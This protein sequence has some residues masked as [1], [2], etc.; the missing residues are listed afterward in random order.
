MADAKG[1]EEL[2]D[3]IAAGCEETFDAVGHD[4][5][6]CA[7]ESSLTAQEMVEDVIGIAAYEAY[8]GEDARAALALVL[9]LYNVTEMSQLVA[10]RL[11]FQ[12]YG[13]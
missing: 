2:L 8:A 10:K 3:I 13:Y 9:E 4:L 12:Y 6:D 5:L 11:K 1:I 7:G